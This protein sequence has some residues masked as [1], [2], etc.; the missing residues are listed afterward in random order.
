M[1]SMYM[2]IAKELYEKVKQ[3]REDGAFEPYVSVTEQERYEDYM[4]HVFSNYK[5]DRTIGFEKDSNI[6]YAL[7][8]CLKTIDKSLAETIESRLSVKISVLFA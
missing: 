8:K 1:Y 7:I 5:T 3:K 4:Y 6:G 2:P